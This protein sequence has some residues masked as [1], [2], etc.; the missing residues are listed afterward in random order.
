MDKRKIQIG[1]KTSDD[2]RV[3]AYD[4]SKRIAP[5]D[6]DFQGVEA[7]AIP[8]HSPSETQGKVNLRT[9]DTIREWTLVK[10]IGKGGNGQVWRAAQKDGLEV[11]LKVLFVQKKNSYPYKRFVAEIKLLSQ[12]GKHRGILPLVDYYLPDQ[13]SADDPACFSMPIATPLSESLKTGLALDAI[14]EA[15]ATFAETLADL[16]AKGISH[17]DIKPGN[18]YEYDGRWVIGDFGIADYPD[19]EALTTSGRKLGP[20]YFMPSEMLENPDT[21]DGSKADVFSLAKTLWTLATGQNYPLK[22]R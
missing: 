18:L 5:A 16:A 22:A 1:E 14:V 12:L 10:R 21:A 15:V 11:A 19:K 2:V 17:R 13:P 6:Q 9:G 20:L 4:T 3:Q 7:R 8:G